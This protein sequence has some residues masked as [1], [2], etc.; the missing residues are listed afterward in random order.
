[1]ASG[2]NA[3]GGSNSGYA[4]A[5]ALAAR[6][7]SAM[8]SF[9]AAMSN[10][11][12]ARVDIV[13]MGASLVEGQA[14]TGYSRNTAQALAG[15]L[16][17]RFPTPGV[18]GG[19]GYIGVP[20]I[21][22]ATAGWPTVFTAGAFDDLTF[23]MGAKHRSWNAQAAGKAVLTVAAGGI[24]SIDLCDVIGPSGGATAGYTK[25]DAGAQVPLSTV[26][27]AIA[28]RRTHFAGPIANTFEYGWNAAGGIVLDGFVEFNGDE[29]AGIQVHNVGHGAFLASQWRSGTSW[30]DSIFQLTPKLI[31]MQDY[32]A[33]D[34]WTAN[35]NLTSAAFGVQMTALIAQIRARGITCPIMIAAIYD[36]S[37]GITLREPWANYVAVQQAIV[38]ADPTLIYVDAGNTKMPATTAA[39]TFNLYDPDL[40]HGAPTGE[41]YHYM[42][43]LILDA[44]VAP[45][46]S[47]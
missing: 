9:Y 24:S 22:V 30:L 37:G 13:H 44:I 2:G 3:A 23:S 8:Q 6:N 11:A 34:G 16:R 41:A 1:M 17:Q 27:G 25:I 19:R 12:N 21:P 33:N 32:G 26:N 31:I 18:A 4:A 14:T 10:R 43:Q 38:S 40:V 46:A 28:V 29:A 45:Q 47:F 35:G 39:Q 42:A 15:L 7:Y 20:T 5:V 36:V